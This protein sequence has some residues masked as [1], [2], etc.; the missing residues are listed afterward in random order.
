MGISRDNR[1]AVRVELGKG[2]VARSEG[3]RSDNVSSASP[4]TMPSMTSSFFVPRTT[5]GA[6]PSIRSM[7]KIKEKQEADK[8]VGRCFLWSDIPF[9]IAKNNP[10]YQSMFDVVAIVGLGY[11]APTYDEL[12]GPILQNEK[13]DCTSRLEELKASWEITGCTVMSDGWTDQ[14]GRTL[15]NFLVNCPRGTM[16]IKSVDASAHVKDATL[17]CEL[18]DGFIQEVGPQNVVQVIMNNAANYVV[19]G[20][21]LMLRYPTL[22]WTPCA[23]HCID[24]ILEDMEKF[25]ISRILLNRLGASQNLYIIMHLCLA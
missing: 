4:S 10:F 8:L 7:V 5:L 9:N 6:Q 15:L 17:L 24:L 2:G 25:L 20:R 19:V 21:L 14:K 11:K 18:L 3:G 12:R 23:A 13:V 1:E 16:F 22:F